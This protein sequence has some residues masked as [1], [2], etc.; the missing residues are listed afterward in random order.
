VIIVSTTTRW[1]VGD[2][3]IAEGALRLLDTGREPVVYFDNVAVWFDY[4]HHSATD[5]API[6]PKSIGEIVSRARAVVFAGTPA[7]LSRP[8]PLWRAAIEHRTPIWLVGVGMYQNKGDLPTCRDAVHKHLVPVATVRDDYAKQMLREAGILDAPC[9]Y[10]PGFHARHT[11]CAA[12]GKI[13]LGYR[14]AECFPQDMWLALAKRFEGRIAG[15][16]VHQPHEIEPARALFG[17]EPFY[18]S[19]YRAYAPVYS[20][21]CIYIGARLH[22]AVAMLASSGEAH[23]IYVARKMA[24]LKRLEGEL[25]V[26][27]YAP[28]AAA[29]IKLGLRERCPASLER[30]QA[31][32][33]AHKAYLCTAGKG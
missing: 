31:D 6:Y 11:P 20:E 4:H 23:V 22:G 7:W 27:V 2:E 18:H 24:M 33:A 13:I 19:D 14:H 30:I 29:S 21:A 28:S 8:L 17:S 1:C 16:V 3:F 12:N 15:I 25:P 9:F 5:A 26:K 10:D 32:F